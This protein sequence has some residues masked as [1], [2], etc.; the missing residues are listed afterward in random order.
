[1]GQ[2]LGLGLDRY[3][4][5]DS[6][7]TSETLMCIYRGV[8]DPD[9]VYGVNLTASLSLQAMAYAHAGQWLESM[10]TYDSIMKG[11]SHSHSHGHM[12]L[13]LSLP[14]SLSMVQEQES[15]FGTGGRGGAGGR[16][17]SGTGAG[18][19]LGGTVSHPQ[20]HHSRVY[21]SKGKTTATQDPSATGGGGGGT[22]GSG[23]TGGGMSS[24]DMI[25][26]YPC[27]DEENG[28]ADGD[29]VTPDE[30]VEQ[31]TSLPAC[32]PAFLPACLPSSLPSSLPAPLPSSLPSS[33]LYDGVLHTISYTSHIYIF[34][35]TFSYIL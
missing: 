20:Q 12:A 17:G 2:G 35:P 29:G 31:V 1:M 25:A 3:D 16:G 33:F 28:Y 6:C 8:H 4:D 19:G 34:Q 5:R 32:L 30:G 13:S 22:G 24:S 7:V 14:P 11:H 15:H 27:L 10:A 9:A 21:G 18:T 26:C 23:G